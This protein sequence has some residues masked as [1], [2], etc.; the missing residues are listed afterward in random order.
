MP[1]IEKIGIG[2]SG[3]ATKRKPKNSEFV[4]PHGAEQNMYMQA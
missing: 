1:A 3:R 2:K 4:P